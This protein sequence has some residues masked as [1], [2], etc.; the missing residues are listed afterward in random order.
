MII[1]GSFGAVEIHA[2]RRPPG[3]GETVQGRIRLGRNHPGRCLTP[4][5]VSDIDCLALGPGHH[6]DEGFDEDPGAALT[7]P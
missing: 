4:E 7:V 1:E 3:D 6:Q 5:P 2:A